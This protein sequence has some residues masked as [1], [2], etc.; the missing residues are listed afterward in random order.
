MPRSAV[1]YLADILE[2]CEAV[3]D[4]L[5]GVDFS[6]YQ[7]TRAIRSAVEREFIIIGEAVAALGRVSPDMFKEISHARMAV[8]F[9]NQLTHDYAAVDDDT[10]FAVAESDLPVLRRECA[11]LMERVGG[12]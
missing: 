3:D 5:R 10:V 4:V 7:S 2:A 9:R 8:G 11:A 1:A 12:A 6:T